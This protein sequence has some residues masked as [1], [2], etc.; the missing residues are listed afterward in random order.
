MFTD[1]VLQFKQRVSFVIMKFNATRKHALLGCKHQM[2]AAHYI[3]DV[4]GY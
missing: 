4:S 2:F 3:Q 1:H